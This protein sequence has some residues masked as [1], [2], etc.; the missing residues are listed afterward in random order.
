VQEEEPKTRLTI[1]YG[2]TKTSALPR[3][4]ILI[5]LVI[6]TSTLHFVLFLVVTVSEYFS[7]NVNGTYGNA[8]GPALDRMHNVLAFPLLPFL[9]RT[10]IDLSDSIGWAAVIFNSL[11]W[12]LVVGAIAVLARWYTHRIKQ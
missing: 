7:M 11:F 1:E 2:V 4:G 8:Y 3:L 9:W 6:A 12:G 5:W 10:K